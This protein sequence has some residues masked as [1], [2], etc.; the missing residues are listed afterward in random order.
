MARQRYCR[1][2]TRYRN[3]LRV[4][5]DP[6]AKPAAKP[7]RKAGFSTFESYCGRETDCLLEG[8]GFE[9]SV[10]QQTRS[11]FRESRVAWRFDRL[12]TRNWKLESS[13]LQRRVRSEPALWRSASPYPTPVHS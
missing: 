7:A 10:P 2:L 6:L 12:A 3:T 11:R 13:A 4:S 5:A 8:D 1:R 9:P